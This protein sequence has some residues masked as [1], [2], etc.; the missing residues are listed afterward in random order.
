MIQDNLYKI[1]GAAKTAV[2]LAVL[3]TCFLAGCVKLE[4]PTLDRKYFT[5][6]VV[7]ADKAKNSIHTDKNLIV[8]RVKISPRYEDRDLVYKVGENGFESDYYNS[9]FVPPA[10][11][12]TQE[13]RVWMGES[14]IFANVLGPDSMGTGE[15]LLEGVVNSIYGDYSGP[16][17]KAVL[18]MQ[19]IMLDNGNPDLPIIYS[20]N[21]SREVRIDGTGPDALVKAM[22]KGLNEIFI[23]L[24]KDLAERISANNFD[25]AQDYSQEK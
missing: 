2:L 5:L 9:F 4:R 21:F 17:H 23:E 16:D 6:D 7:R 14:G 8:R 12:V 11:M 3:L 10:A 20:R 15:L 13:L 18:K 24:E 1:Y 25:S 19:F 22:N